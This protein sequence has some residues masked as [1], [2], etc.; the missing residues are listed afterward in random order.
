MA[1]LNYM[2]LHY[3]EIKAR[4]PKYD[5]ADIANQY[6]ELLPDP[7]LVPQTAENMRRAVLYRPPATV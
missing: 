6:L 2:Y 5:I 3:D 7:F 1:A 4:L